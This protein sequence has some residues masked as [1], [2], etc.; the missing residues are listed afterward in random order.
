MNYSVLSDNLKGEY[1]SVFDQVELYGILKGIGEEIMDDKMVNLYDM[2]LTAQQEEKPAEKIIGK[3]TEVFCKEYFGD[4]DVKQWIHEITYRIYRLA[5][6][7]FVVEL[8]D[9]Y[10]WSW[11]DDLLHATSDM[12]PL[13]CGIVGGFALDIIA[14]TFLKPMMFKIKK[15]PPIAY[16]FVIII[17]FI[18][19]I[20]FDVKVFMDKSVQIPVLP[21]LI[22][23][24]V[25]IAGFL[26]Y[27]KLKTGS[28]QKK[29]NAEAEYIRSLQKTTSITGSPDVVKGFV[30]QLAKRY[31][32]INRKR[33]KQGKAPLSQA[34]FAE[35]IKKE[36]EKWGVDSVWHKCFYGALT[37]ACGAFC[38][39]GV[40]KEYILFSLLAVGVVVVM[41]VLIYCGF[42]KLER[43]G[44]N[45]RK[46]IL[47]ECEQE[48]ITILEYDKRMNDGK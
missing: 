37:M 38:W 45:I 23:S 19:M 5:V 41:E 21:V 32:K 2:L 46:R 48:N 10:L 17:L 24:G 42:R 29:R 35:Q 39:L 33:K 6:I 16:Y 3:S 11:Q 34:E 18:G 9:V 14:T 26:G 1:K 20:A 7:I 13:I 30:K 25:Y 28:F 27:R 43:S 4:Y 47:E 31:E 15:I 36:R 40:S 44:E 12:L 22:V 8:M